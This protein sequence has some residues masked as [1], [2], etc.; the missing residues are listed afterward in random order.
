MSKI[1]TQLPEE[2]FEHIL[3]KESKKNKDWRW[4]LIA[5]L[6]RASYTNQQ[7]L[8]K[9][10]SQISIR[11]IAEEAEITKKQAENA[12]RHFS[13]INTHGKVRGDV[14]AGLRPILR[15]HKRGH[16]RGQEKELYDILL[17]GYYEYEGTQ[18]ET[19][20]ETVKETQRGHKG[21][22]LPRENAYTNREA[23]KLSRPDNPKP[24]NPRPDDWQILVMDLLEAGIET[25]YHESLKSKGIGTVRK[26]LDHM[27]S[28]GFV[29]NETPIQCIRFL[30][31]E[32]AWT[33]SIAK[34]MI[35]NREK[36]LQHFEDGKIYD[37]ATCGI[38]STE[39]WFY[40]G[41][42]PSDGACF[43]KPNFMANL[44]NVLT[45][46]KIKNPFEKEKMK[47]TG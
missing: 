33:W 40:R 28:P 2:L 15:G 6:R 46:L 1:F 22:S 31:R 42:Q 38:N 13:G 5:I 25:K 19:V 35:S 41:T 16:K 4:A 11:Q 9:G 3:W 45:R 10:Q 23:K 14:A 29:I 18:K 21:D 17:I 20:K 12:I 26:A 43:E 39:I 8:L 44:T 30:I 27:N 34:P 47:K 32:K 36:M 24:Q 37:G 7:D